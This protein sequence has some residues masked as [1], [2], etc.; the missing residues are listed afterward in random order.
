MTLLSFEGIDVDIP[1]IDGLRFFFENGS[2]AI[3]CTNF[4][5]RFALSKPPPKP[6]ESKKRVAEAPSPIVIYEDPAKRQKT[7]PAK[8]ASSSSRSDTSE[9]SEKARSP[10]Q[11]LPAKSEPADVAKEFMSPP[12]KAK[13]KRGRPTKK[14][15][16]KKTADVKSFFSPKKDDKVDA[17]KA[18]EASSPSDEVALD[19][20]T[21][22]DEAPE[23]TVVAA[24]EDDEAKAAAPTI[25]PTS[26]VDVDALPAPSH[27][28][29]HFTGSYALVPT[30]GTPPSQR[31]GATA[32]R[33]SKD[34]IVLYGG[35]S[36]DETT[37][38]D[39]HVFDIAT[40]AWSRPA[41]CESLPRTWHGAV[42]LPTNKLLVVFGGER[43]VN[44]AMETLADPMVL[45]TEAFLWYPP[46]VAGPVPVARSGHSMCRLGSDIVVFGGNRGRSS[47]NSVHVLETAT[48]TWRNIRVDGRAPA[49]RN[50]HSAVAIGDHRMVLFGGN[51]T[52]RSFDSVH[53]LER[54]P[55]D[56][57][58]FWFHPCTVGVGPAPR[59]GQIAV[60]LDASTIL[61]YGGWD[62][63]VGAQKTTLFGDVFALN[64]E[65]WEW[66][67]VTMDSSDGMQR[68]GHCAVL[69]NEGA[70]TVLLF[71]GQDAHETRSN[72][73][74]S[75]TLA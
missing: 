61:V 17:A 28:L 63:Q 64:T 65:T 12:A 48:W 55:A 16:V 59:T 69:A 7:S 5:G 57:A 21:E 70:K 66:K 34:R 31:W 49:A 75:L 26:P 18:V 73:V 10:L 41:N 24:T 23:A 38:A 25:V 45:D 36:E 13:G 6:T 37:L 68:V 8:A 27:G 22:V 14:D 42:Y 43:L 47:M 20:T 71:G 74:F 4:T 56:N 30:S 33:I 67:P 46:V 72:E 2:L 54:R 51:D 53:V 39:I 35:E 60:A 44:D 29:E 58:W 3:E 19:E 15:A 52:K 62:P 1:A 40:N 9:S 11:P 50:Y 32:T